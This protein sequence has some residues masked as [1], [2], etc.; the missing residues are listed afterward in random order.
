[1]IQAYVNAVL[2]VLESVLNT[3][4]RLALPISLLAGLLVIAGVAA[5]EW[6]R[7]RTATADG[8]PESPNAALFDAPQ[9]Y[10]KNIGSGLLIL[11]VFVSCWAVLKASLPAARQNLQWRDSAEATTNPVPDAPPVQ[12]YGPSASVMIERTYSRN[13]TLPPNFLERVGTDGVAVIAPYL[14]DPSA[15]NVIRLSD[16]FRK[17][18]RDVILTREVTRRDE[19]PVLFR[20]AQ[21]AVQFKPLSGRAYDAQFEGRYTFQNPN[22]S[23]ADMRFNFPLPSAGTLQNLSIAVGGQAIADPSDTGAYEW[24]A[25]VGA[26]ETR[27]VVVRYQVVGA[28]TWQYEMGSQRRRVQKFGLQA[29][30]G[31]GENVRF[32]RGSLTPNTINNR[33][34]RWELDNVVTG[35][36]IALSFAPSTA[37]EELYLQA[38]SGLPASLAA[39]LVSV[40][41]LM[42]YREKTLRPNALV[43]GIL[44]F[45]FGLGAAPI[46]ANYVGF[47]S[48]LIIGPLVGGLLATYALGKRWYLLAALPATLLPA[49][50]LSGQHSGLLLLVLAAL[51]LAGILRF[52]RKASM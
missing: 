30:V 34:L 5:A 51:T 21:V 40:C 26:N 8:T 50:F 45:T 24:K 48:A 25:R 16:T 20:T 29:T 49:A 33:D 52:A 6:G 28:R 39:F 37:S 14:S 38:L 23:P 43:T 4:V 10:A 3:G 41:V 32:L 11:L 1:M 47:T 35:Q 46:L 27:E 12:Q 44:L 42:A 22:A 7:R 19:E 13:L 31:G 9:R 36:R 2:H 15:E 17:S 18:G